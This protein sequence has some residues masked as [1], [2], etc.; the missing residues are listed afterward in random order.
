LSFFWRLAKEPSARFRLK[1]CQAD[2][3]Y[4][5]LDYDVRLLLPDTQHTILP[6]GLVM[7]KVDQDDSYTAL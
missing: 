3:R 4:Y 7:D 5:A 6:T 2:H 1:N